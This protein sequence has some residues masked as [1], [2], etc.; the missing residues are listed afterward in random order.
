MMLEQVKKYLRIDESE[1]DGFL[2]LLINAAKLDLKD[3]GVPE[4]KEKDER[5]DLAVMLYCSL[6]YENRDPSIKIDKLNFAYQ[7]LILKLKRYGDA[8]ESSTF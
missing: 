7:S 3:S 8:D 2:A 1:D 4:P 6:H 5:Y